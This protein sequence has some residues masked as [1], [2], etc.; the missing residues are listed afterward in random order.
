MKF[1]DLPRKHN[2]VATLPSDLDQDVGFTD[3]VWNE[4]FQ[5]AIF[6]KALERSQPHFSDETWIMFAKSWIEK[7]DVE[8]VAT[9]LGTSVDRIYVARSR[10]LKR[11]RY[12]VTLLGRRPSHSIG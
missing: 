1:D 12:E 9:D 7:V 3:S 5:Q 11:L 8:Q 2:D 4:H 6:A 10:V